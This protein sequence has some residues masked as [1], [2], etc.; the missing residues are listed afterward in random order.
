MKG[1]NLKPI[2][3]KRGIFTGM[4]LLSFPA[5]PI[6]RRAKYKYRLI[7]IFLFANWKPSI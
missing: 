3:A 5:L 1:R 4:L 2:I 7:E 6:D